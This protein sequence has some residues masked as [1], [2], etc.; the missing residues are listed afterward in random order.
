MRWD[1]VAVGDD[2]NA[3]LSADGA[4]LTWET[5]RD[6]NR[7]IYVSTTQGASLLN[8]SN[9]PAEDTTPAWR[10]CR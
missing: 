5:N 3:S 9:D 2:V 7:E 6:G 1:D 10:P 4:R 8:L